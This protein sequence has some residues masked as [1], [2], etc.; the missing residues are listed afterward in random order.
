MST[1]S[2][3]FKTK[4]SD[5]K[6]RGNIHAAKTLNQL[7]MQDL[8]SLGKAKHS[9]FILIDGKKYE[10]IESE[11]QQFFDALVDTADLLSAQKGSNIL[12]T[13]EVADLLNVSRPYVVKLVDTNEIPSFKVGNQRRVRELD[14]LE[15]RKKMRN[16]QSRALDELTVETEKL[17]L[18]FK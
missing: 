12:S 14:A 4:K 16:K 1:K 11:Q 17:G 5:E 18:E 10:V 6:K 15:Y 3:R 9:V 7:R 2:S 8:R 13:Q